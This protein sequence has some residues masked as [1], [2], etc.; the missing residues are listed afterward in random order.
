MRVM[1]S[2]CDIHTCVRSGMPFI[3]GSSARFTVSMARPY[4]RLGAGLTSPPKKWAKYC[5]P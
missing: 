2:P 3:N 4:S 1:V 5:A